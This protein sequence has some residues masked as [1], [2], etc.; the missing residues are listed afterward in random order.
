MDAFREA[1]LDLAAFADASLVDISSWRPQRWRC[2]EVHGSD[3][4]GKTCVRRRA[5]CS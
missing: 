4:K 3:N 2:I 1:S 5:W